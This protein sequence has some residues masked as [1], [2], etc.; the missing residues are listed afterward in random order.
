LTTVINLRDTDNGTRR[1]VKVREHECAI[2]IELEGCTDGISMQLKNDKLFVC[3]MDE[4]GTEIPDCTF[5]LGVSEDAKKT[6]YNTMF[7]VG[8]SCVHTFDN[9]EDIPVGEILGALNRRIA[10]LMLNPDEAAEAFGINDTYEE[11]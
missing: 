9:P 10:H 1:D 7:D 8:F 5:A 6:R 2:D 4:E 11:T 3:K